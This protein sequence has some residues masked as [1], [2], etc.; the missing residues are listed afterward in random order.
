MDNAKTAADM[1][2]WG[3]SAIP[4]RKDTKRP[5]LMSWKGNQTTAAPADQIERWLAAG[6]NLAV[7][8][9]TVSGVIVLDIDNHEEDGQKS[10]DFV[11]AARG[12]LPAT[13]VVQTGSGGLHYY[14][15]HPGHD[16]RNKAGFKAGGM[17]WL[18]GCDFRGDGGY[19]VAPPSMHQSGQPYQWLSTPD[20]GIADAPPWLLE[21]IAACQTGDLAPLEWL[22]AIAK[23]S[24]KPNPALPPIPTRQDAPGSTISPAPL[25]PGPAA[26]GVTEVSPR[27]AAAV[28]ARECQEL[29]ST[30]EGSRNDRLNVAAFNLA[31]LVN[32]GAISREEVLD[33]LA[34][35]AKR[36]GLGDEETVATIESAFAKSGKK[37]RRLRVKADAR[38]ANPDDAKALNVKHPAAIAAAYL[39][40]A[41]NTPEGIRLRRFSATWL[42]S[43]GGCYVEITD[44]DIRAHLRG[45]LETAKLAQFK[46]L[47]SG[48]IE[49]TP[50]HPTTT[51]VNEVLDA[52]E[53]AANV[54]ASVQQPAWT[55]L[56][57]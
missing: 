21:V 48:D 33:G 5:A 2:K 15:R 7:V 54:T 28:L 22:R 34:G 56:E 13:A 10:L 39:H 16:C 30:R 18:P 4:T 24:I 45:W 32:A 17:C 23:P 53:S 49:M 52:M 19:V 37:Q 11:I 46:S 57:I 40:D 43:H 1:V 42:A 29:E 27:Y 9:G 51:T 35:A 26:D 44:P 47:K 55:Q 38:P 50:V 41:W 12:A 6:H 31:S 36:A 20:D 14:F 8:T 3:F 25:T